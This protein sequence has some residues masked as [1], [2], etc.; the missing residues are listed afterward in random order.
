MK[1]TNE[2][3]PAELRLELAELLGWTDI[4]T[5]TIW[6]DIYEDSYRTDILVGTAPGTGT[7]C[8]GC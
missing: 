4:K 2:M 5:K 8:R 6:E 1:P 7:T 3:T